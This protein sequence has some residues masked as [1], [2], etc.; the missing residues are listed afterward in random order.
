MENT[1]LK[2]AQKRIS[3]AL[4]VRKKLRGT[5]EKPRLCVVKTNC[6][7]QLQLI[8]DDKGVTVASLSTN[9]KALK[10]TAFARKNKESARALAGM[11]ADKLKALGVVKLVFDRGAHKFHGILA[12]VAQGLRDQGL[13]F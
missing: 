4:R 8:D 3:R 5:E 7:I 13:Q 11:F 1:N 12:E 6:H 2:N 9:A 10:D